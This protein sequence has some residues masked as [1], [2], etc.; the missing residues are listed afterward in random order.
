MIKLMIISLSSYQLLDNLLRFI[1]SLNFMIT[2]LKSPFFNLIHQ[3]SGLLPFINLVDKMLISSF[4][5]SHSITLK[6]Y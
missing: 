4:F 2:L 5:T 6:L 1:F 3:Q